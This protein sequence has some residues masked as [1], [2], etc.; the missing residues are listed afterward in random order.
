MSNLPADRDSNL[1]PAF[2]APEKVTFIIAAVDWF[3]RV[4]RPTVKPARRADFAAWQRYARAELKRTQ[5][6]L[7]FLKLCKFIRKIKVIAIKFRLR[8]L[9][10]LVSALNLLGKILVAPF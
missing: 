5:A 9:G 2:T 1:G 3:D 4:Y 7:L 6:K 8:V 10:G